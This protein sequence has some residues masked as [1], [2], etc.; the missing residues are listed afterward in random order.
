MQ[1]QTYN[2]KPPQ[3]EYIGKSVADLRGLAKGAIM[4]LLQKGIQYD[5]LLEEGV[6]EKVLRELYTELNIAV[7]GA[8]ATKAVSAEMEMSRDK[9]PSV[10]TQNDTLPTE[11]AK[12]VPT[13]SEN[14]ATVALVNT[15]VAPAAQ[16]VISSA[17]LTKAASP[18]LERK[19]RIAQLLAAKAGRPSPSRSMSGSV[20]SL[21]PPDVQHSSELPLPSRSDASA[22]SGGASSSREA[23]LP[24]SQ[25]QVQESNTA[26]AFNADNDPQPTVPSVPNI[27]IP[28]RDTAI[29]SPLSSAIPGLFMSSND[30]MHVDENPPLDAVAANPD[31]ATR[32]SQKRSHDQVSQSTYSEP[33]AKRPNTASST[34]DDS[35]ISIKDSGN[36]AAPTGGTA[37]DSKPTSDI[38]ASRIALEAVEPA[39]QPE[40][41]SGTQLTEKEFA[42][43]ASMLKARFLKQRAERQ[44]ALQ[45]GLPDLNAEVQ[46]TRSRLQQ[47]QMRLAQLRS[48]IAHLGHDLS[49]A[50]NE[51]RTT[52]EEIQ[53]LERQVQEGVSGQKQYNDELRNLSN[54]NESVKLGASSGQVGETITGPAVSTNRTEAAAEPTANGHYSSEDEGEVT[55]EHRESWSI[56]TVALRGR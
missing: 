27:E 18:S 49:E 51:E 11:L 50:R 41:K 12:D 40:T 1:A 30:M 34:A 55:S 38:Q 33:L 52:V 23:Q 14:S 44:K 10:P 48:R 37:E 31:P 29:Q 15:T 28:T 4:S 20:A 6:N 13:I 2:S 39:R 25:L 32:T 7:G 17:T 36:L 19:D 42:E 43:K 24:A 8:P 16:T 56:Y 9:P 5:T 45:D 47:Q 26:A 3:K 21:G 35:A 53:R 46:K 54:S 22:S